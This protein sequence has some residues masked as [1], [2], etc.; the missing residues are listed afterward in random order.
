[1][2]VVVKK[3][4]MRFI[5]ITDATA[6][7]LTRTILKQLELLGLDVNKIRGLGYDGA[8]V[9]SGA[10]GGVQALMGRYLNTKWHQCVSTVCASYITQPQLNYQ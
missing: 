4:F 5:S 10:R 7:G 6:E 1:M 8:S 2:S 9:M 3:T